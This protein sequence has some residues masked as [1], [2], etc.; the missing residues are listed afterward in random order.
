[1]LMLAL[2]QDAQYARGVLVGLE[3]SE[4][5]GSLAWKSPDVARSHWLRAGSRLGA[6]SGD[7]LHDLNGVEHDPSKGHL[8]GDEADLAERIALVR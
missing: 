6:G 5:S 8:A 7:D 4:C 1:M 3:C 2:E